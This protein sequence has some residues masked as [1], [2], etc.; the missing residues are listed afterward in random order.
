VVDRSRVLLACT[1]LFL[2]LLA[3]FV[4]HGES[5]TLIGTITCVVPAQLEVNLDQGSIAFTIDPDNASTDQI[6]RLVSVGTNAPPVTF[7]ISLLHHSPIF[8]YRLTEQGVAAGTWEVIPVLPG[9]SWESLPALGW[10]DY[11]LDLR[12]MAG[13]DLAAGVYPDD[14]Q[15]VFQT[16][17]IIHTFLLPRSNSK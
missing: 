2:L 9:V 10:T 11:V 8:S 16:S 7:G 13:P 5:R 3:S 1:C 17:G 4:A 14:I 15:L 12:G 6:L